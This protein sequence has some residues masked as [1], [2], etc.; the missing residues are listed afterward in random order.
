MALGSEAGTGQRHSLRLSGGSQEDQTHFSA[1]S[2]PSHPPGFCRA[3]CRPIATALGPQIS[4]SASHA[5]R[6]FPVLLPPAPR[7]PEEVT[8]P[9]EET[10][11]PRPAPPTAFPPTTRRV[12]GA[13][14]E[15]RARA[16]PPHALPFPPR[17]AGGRRDFPRDWLRGGLSRPPLCSPAARRKWEGKPRARGAAILDKG[18]DGGAVEPAEQSLRERR[19]EVGTRPGRC[20]ARAE[21]SS[22][23]RGTGLPPAEP[24]CTATRS[25]S[26]GKEEPGRG[27]TEH[28]APRFC[29]GGSAALPGPARGSASSR[30][31]LRGGGLGGSHRA[32]LLG[33]VPH[34][35]LRAALGRAAAA[36]AAQGGGPRG[37]GR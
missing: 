34:R 9:P 31:C 23:R 3:R 14:R 8:T 20:P 4:R 10:Q 37:P 32:A 12:P 16:R 22:A 33:T 30:R 15:L 2:F 26:P 21:R 1:P 24:R 35:A 27:G 5:R 28:Q 29:L 18:G 19:S 11:P 6:A 36:A 13:G 7:P 25:R 17:D